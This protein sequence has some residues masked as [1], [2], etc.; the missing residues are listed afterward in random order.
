MGGVAEVEFVVEEEGEVAVEKV[1]MKVLVEA[2]V[3]SEDM[4]SIL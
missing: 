4:E 2:V 1:W 3:L